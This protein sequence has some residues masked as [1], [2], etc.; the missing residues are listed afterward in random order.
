M[1]SVDPESNRCDKGVK[2]KR[3]DILTELC[4]DDED[5]FGH[6]FTESTDDLNDSSDSLKDA[7]ELSTLMDNFIFD[8]DISKIRNRFLTQT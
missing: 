3:D 6:D 7:D 5:D 2:R 1:N 4:A 8:D